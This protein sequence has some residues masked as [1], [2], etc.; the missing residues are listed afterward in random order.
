MPPELADSISSRNSGSLKD[1][2]SISELP[3]SLVSGTPAPIGMKCKRPQ[4]CPKAPPCEK[5]QAYMRG[6]R[7]PSPKVNTNREIMRSTRRGKF[8]G[9]LDSRWRRHNCRGHPSPGL[10]RLQLNPDLREAIEMPRVTYSKQNRRSTSG[11]LTSRFEVVYKAVASANWAA[12]PE[13]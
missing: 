1:I 3:V 9:L 10:A 7:L 5:N 2:I 12:W 13:C 4:L 8:G 6:M 11:S